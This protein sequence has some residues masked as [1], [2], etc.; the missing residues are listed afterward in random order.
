MNE[1]ETIQDLVAE[2]YPEQAA[3]VLF[4]ATILAGWGAATSV[5][6]RGRADEVTE[7]YLAALRLVGLKISRSTL[8]SWRRAYRSDGPRGLVDQRGCVG[9]RPARD[10]TAFFGEVRRLYTGP[11]LRSIAHC[12][13][14]ACEWAAEHELP[15]ATYRETQRFIRREILPALTREPGAS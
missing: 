5:C 4:R 15:S 9:P 6:E 11:G 2:L 7:A 3:Q 10:C 14:R 1:R 13:E 12:H 8:F